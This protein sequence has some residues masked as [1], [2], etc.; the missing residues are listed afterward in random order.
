MRGR[1]LNCQSNPRG[2]VHWNLLDFRQVRTVVVF[3]LLAAIAGNAAPAAEAPQGQ[4]D[5]SKSLFAVLAAINVAGYDAELTAASTHPLRLQLRRSIEARNLRSA[6]RLTRFFDAHRKPDA[7]DELSQYITLALSLDGPPDFKW[8]YSPDRTPPAALA[9]EDMIPLLIEF[10]K[11]ADLENE[12]KAAQP[13]YDRIIAANHGPVTDAI[14]QA[15]LYLRNPTSGARGRRFQIYIDLLGAPNQVHSR[16]FTDDYFVVVTPTAHPR[17]K[18][19]RRAYLHYL[20]DPLA[21]RATEAIKKKKQLCVMADKAPILGEVYK[22][23]CVLLFG[24]SLVRAVESRIDHDPPEAVNAMREGFV[25]TGYFA[26]TLVGYEK[27]EQSLRF[28]LEEMVNNI[29]VKEEAPKIAAIPYLERPVEHVVRAAQVQPQIAETPIERQ[30]D[31]VDKLIRARKAEAA[32]VIC[33]KVLQQAGSKSIHARAYF[34]LARIAALE[35]DPD[36]SKELFERTLTLEPEPFEKAW[37]HVYLA[38]LAMASQEPEEA[39]TQYEAAL[40][41]DGGSEQARQAAQTE[42]EAVRSRK[43]KP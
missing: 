30:L 32:R 2:K 13:A 35:K 7:R 24:M 6:R 39:I 15:N 27:Q 38:R 31:D 36:L 21:I 11:E 37:S 34:G 10:W 4:L 18:D 8:H 29:K 40:A 19:I 43:Q 33:R 3:L 1:F 20:I 9:L 12:W 41:V 22:Q 14:L 16:S 28:Y 42:V 17:V 25:M 26:D 23:D 5:G